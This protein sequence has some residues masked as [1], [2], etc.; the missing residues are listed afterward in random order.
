[1]KHCKDEQPAPEPLRM[2]DIS[3]K[4]DPDV[5][6][7]LKAVFVQMQQ[8]GAA[9]EAALDMRTVL[10]ET[11]AARSVANPAATTDTS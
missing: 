11:L 1:M 9:L 6:A 8:V 2:A 10:F 5:Q 4:L 7:E 3:D